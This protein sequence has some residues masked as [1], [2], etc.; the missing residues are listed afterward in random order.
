[1]SACRK[2]GGKGWIV[3][4]TDTE[5]EEPCPE[6]FSVNAGEPVYTLP[7]IRERVL[8]TF[9][10]HP[11]WRRYRDDWMRDLLARAFPDSSRSESDNAG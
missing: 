7:E 10:A 3:E 5:W 1:M 6:C 2:C 4:P 9:A 8:A 11:E